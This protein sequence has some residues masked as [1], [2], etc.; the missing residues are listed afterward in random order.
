M[1]SRTR[2]ARDR[3]EV[4]DLD[5]RQFVRI[6]RGCEAHLPISDQY[7][8]DRPQRRGAWW[9]SQQEHMVRWFGNQD[10]TGSG[11]FTRA[12]PNTSAR[13]TYNRLL[14]PAAFAWMAEAL[15]EDP[16]VVQAAADA[17]RAE[18][19]ARRRPGLLRRHLPWDRLLELALARQRSQR[20]RA[21]IT[22]RAVP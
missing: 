10:S 20:S 22:R 5:V 16:A 7:E 15:G 12:T 3:S 17:A 13:V 1:T 21:S 18:P 9:S 8:K 11:A 19:E 6:L 14:C 2:E 4:D